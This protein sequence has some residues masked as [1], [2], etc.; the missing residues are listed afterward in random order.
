MDGFY[1]EL[2]KYEDREV[3]RQK[4]I[5]VFETEMNSDIDYIYL[6]TEDEDSDFLIKSY[7]EDDPRL[8]DFEERLESGELDSVEGLP[9][10]HMDLRVSMYMDED[11]G[12]WEMHD[13]YISKMYETGCS[14]WSIPWEPDHM[15]DG[16]RECVLRVLDR[17]VI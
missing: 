10:P 12:K 8:H 9:Y 2:K 11:T 3:D 6:F 14:L 17:V 1:K 4:F 16:E 15:T 7:E 5:E 13:I